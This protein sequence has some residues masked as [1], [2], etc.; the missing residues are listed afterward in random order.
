MYKAADNVVADQ[1]AARATP[2]TLVIDH[3]G[4]VLYH[5]S[6]DDSQDTAQILN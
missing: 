1:F 3:S 2:E 6:I 5:G 4:T